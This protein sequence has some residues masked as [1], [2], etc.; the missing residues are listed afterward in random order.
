MEKAAEEASEF[1]YIPDIIIDVD[2][3]H[4]K[5]PLYK[6]RSG[7]L[8]NNLVT[9][10]GTLDTVYAT[11]N[12]CTS[13]IYEC[14][15]CSDR[16]RKEQVG[17]KKKR[18][19]EC[20]CGSNKFRTVEEIYKDRIRFTVSRQKEEEVKIKCKLITEEVRGRAKDVLK[21]GNK[22]R[23][24]GIVDVEDKSDKKDRF[25]DPYISVIAYD[26]KD[27]TKSLD[28]FSKE[29]IEEVKSKTEG[30]VNPFKDFAKS[31]AP[32]IVDSDDVKKVIA[33]SLIGAPEAK[34][35]GR[36]HSFIISN[37][38][39]GK[40]DMLKFN[41]DVFPNT[42]YADGKNATGPG[43]TGTVEQQKGGQWKLKAGKIVY[44]DQGV[45]ALDEFDKMS[46]S[47]AEKLNTAMVQPSFPVDMAGTNAHLPGQATVIAAGNFK[48]YLDADSDDDKYIKEYIPDHAASLLDR[49][50]LIYAMYG[51]SDSEEVEEAILSSFSDEESLSEDSFF[52]EDEVVIF[53]ELAKSYDPSLTQTS[54][55]FIK[56]WLRGQ[57]TVGDSKG[58]S[59]FNADSN[60]Y[61]VTLAKLTCMFAR[62]RFAERTNENDAQRAIQLVQMCR[63]SRGVSDGE[64]DINQV[65]EQQRR[66]RLDIV[67]GALEDLDDGD[68][69][70]PEDVANECPLSVSQVEDLLDELE[71]EVHEVESGRYQVL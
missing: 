25:A 45:L 56:Q 67:R 47:D 13:I 42:H 15:Q 5:I 9:V 70:M 28:D 33:A 68:G 38:G 1:N 31:L 48:D 41:E 69:V 18:P 4:F 49:F 50:S 32:E 59:S 34:D 20:D 64:S 46:R 10:E 30:R 65:Q 57:K 22:V 23:I 54:K 44:A 55:E 11:D 36:I 26:Q 17:D 37:P 3:D 58:E 6:S 2:V 24:T 52:D 16:Y 66:N 51:D 62:T 8:I 21:P 27:K 53:R 29:E 14:G 71:N 19:Y 39:G 35:D 63:E 12:V 40:S 60:R 61:L 43:L 7:K